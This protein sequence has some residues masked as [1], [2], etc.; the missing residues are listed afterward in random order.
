[1]NIV[2]VIIESVACLQHAQDQ[3]D[4]K[5]SPDGFVVRGGVVCGDLHLSGVHQFQPAAQPHGT[6]LRG[7]R[8]PGDAALFHVQPRTA[9][10]TAGRLFVFVQDERVRLLWSEKRN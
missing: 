2:A 5:C 4:I 10:G 8:V 9:G 6:L 3:R 1:M 7:M